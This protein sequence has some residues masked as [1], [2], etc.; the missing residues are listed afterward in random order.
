VLCVP[1]ATLPALSAHPKPGFTAFKPKPSSCL[2]SWHSY[3]APESYNGSSSNIDP[4]HLRK[5][6]ER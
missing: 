5:R 3:H 2:T 1:R 4:P 6:D